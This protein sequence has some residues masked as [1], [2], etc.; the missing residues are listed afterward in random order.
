M[1]GTSPNAITAKAYAKINLSLDVLRRRED[2]FHDLTSVMQTVSLADTI[3]FWFGD[4]RADHGEDYSLIDRAI[5]SVSALTRNAKPIAYSIQK[6]IPSAAGLGGGSS[7]CAT[8][9]RATERLMALNLSDEQ[10]LEIA[11]EL[12]S[13]VPF[14][15][16]GGTALVEGRGER[17][18]A[19]RDA[20]ERAFLLLNG[21][22][23]VSTGDVFSKLEPS[24]YS[25]G[26]AS[27]RVLD[28]FR[29]D[30][31]VFGH[32]ALTAAAMQ[33]CDSLGCLLERVSLLL[34]PTRVALSGSGGTVVGLFDS[35]ADALPVKT[36]LEKDVPFVHLA[37]SVP[38]SVSGGQWEPG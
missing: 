17:V 22:M 38:R 14:F 8:A 15:L 31:L 34:G 23:P 18:T 1:T 36:E 12:G 35:V 11:S 4:E 6:R 26:A 33:T 28:A 37:V 30:D 7:D 24:A 32:N 13:D 16:T 9:I 2:G 5:E 27:R 25:D 20:P 29:R 10:R 19:L 3:H 21:G